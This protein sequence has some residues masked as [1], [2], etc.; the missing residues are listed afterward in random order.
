MIKLGHSW[1]SSKHWCRG[2]TAIR[3]PYSPLRNCYPV[4]YAGL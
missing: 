2:R 1:N 3:Q 4:Y